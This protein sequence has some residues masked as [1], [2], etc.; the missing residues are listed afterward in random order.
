MNSGVV[1][2]VLRSK[3]YSP[4]LLYWNLNV[5]I[6]ARFKLNCEVIPLR[7]FANFKLMSRHKEFRGALGHGLCVNPPL[8]RTFSQGLGHRKESQIWIEKV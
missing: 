5:C 7:G 3:Q 1:I 2:F 6:S 4:A 8:V